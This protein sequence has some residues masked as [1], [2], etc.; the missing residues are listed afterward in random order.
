MCQLYSA[1]QKKK[2]KDKVNSVF[3]QFGFDV[4]EAPWYSSLPTSSLYKPGSNHA[5]QF[6]ALHHKTLLAGFFR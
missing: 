4:W 6:S 3:D 1:L 2:K 5:S